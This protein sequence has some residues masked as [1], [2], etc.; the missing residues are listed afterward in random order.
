MCVLPCLNKLGSLMQGP[1]S[2]AALPGL[3]RSMGDAVLAARDEYVFGQMPIEHVQ[4]TH[5]PITVQ[6]IA[7]AS[8]APFKHNDGYSPL[9][10]QTLSWAPVDLGGKTILIPIT[11][12]ADSEPEAGFQLRLQEL[13]STAI[14]PHAL[15]EA[16]FWTATSAASTTVSKAIARLD[17][18]LQTQDRR[19]APGDEARLAARSIRPIS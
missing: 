17:G 15:R 10:D 6:P 16:G 5:G 1:L 7:T 19:V 11:A 18:A 13:V 3:D 14:L 4:P 9:Q 12:D 8:S 2:V